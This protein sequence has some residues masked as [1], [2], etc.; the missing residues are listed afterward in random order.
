MTTS[1]PHSFIS[2]SPA[3]PTARSQTAWTCYSAQAETGAP[4]TTEQRAPWPRSVNG[5]LMARQLYQDRQQAR[6]RLETPPPTWAFTWERVTG[7]EPALSAWEADVLPLNYTRAAPRLCLNSPG[8]RTGTNGQ[9]GPDGEP[10]TGSRSRAGQQPYA[11][12]APGAA[13]LSSASAE[14]WRS[15]A[16]NSAHSCSSLAT[17]ASSS[18][19]RRMPA[20][21][22]PS[23]VR[24]TTY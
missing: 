21:V 15:R 1:G 20:S 23:L 18:R 7:I 10:A 4:T 11:R 3:L 2:T 19:I 9:P 13:S 16:R 17:W 22:T 24:L 8:H 14:N 5:P 6:P 12:P